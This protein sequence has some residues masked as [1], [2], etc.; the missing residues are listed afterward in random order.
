MADVWETASWESE[1]YL[2]KGDYLLLGILLLII[3]DCELWYQRQERGKATCLSRLRE[4]A[5]Q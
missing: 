2:V 5:S 1:W 3:P 4:L